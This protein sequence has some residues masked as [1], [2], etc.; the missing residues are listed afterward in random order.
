MPVVTDPQTVELQRTRVDRDILEVLRGQGVHTLDQL[1][2]HDEW[3]VVNWLLNALDE[4]NP[5][6][7]PNPI[8]REAIEQFEKLR[9]VTDYYCV[10]FAGKRHTPFQLSRMC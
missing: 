7:D 5:H 10:S 1:I 6:D 2:A 3:T 9:E 4:Q 8:I